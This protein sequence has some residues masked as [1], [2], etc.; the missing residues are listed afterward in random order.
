VKNALGR[1]LALAFIA[2]MLLLISGLGH[3]LYEV[4]TAVHATRIRDE[5]LERE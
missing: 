5:L 2:A 4:R 1:T 3:F